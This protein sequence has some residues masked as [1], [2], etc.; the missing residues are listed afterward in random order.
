MISS[1]PTATVMSSSCWLYW[2]L[3]SE[4]SYLGEWMNK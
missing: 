4:Q 2:L 3:I 1:K